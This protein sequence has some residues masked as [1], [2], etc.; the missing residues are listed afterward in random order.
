M[1]GQR[2]RRGSAHAT[3]DSVGPPVRRCGSP[4]RVPPRPVTGFGRPPAPAPRE[5]WPAPTGARVTLPAAA[6]RRPRA[7]ASLTS[8]WRCSSR[9]RACSCCTRASSSARAAFNCD[10]SSVLRANCQRCTPCTGQCRV[11]LLARLFQPLV[12]LLIALELLIALLD[13]LRRRRRDMSTVAPRAAPRHGRGSFSPSNCTENHLS[14]SPAWRGA[15]RSPCPTVGGMRIGAAPNRREPAFAA[16]HLLRG[17]ILEE[18]DAILVDFLKLARFILDQAAQVR[19]V[20]PRCNWAA[21]VQRLPD[22]AP[23]ER[24]RRQG[25]P[26]DGGGHA[27]HRRPGRGGLHCQQI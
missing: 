3:R 27:P 26:M 7:K 16:S 6:H 21:E 18:T 8:F 23:S 24:R 19:V 2:E 11:P 5:V 4:A 12:G 13:Q 9:R 17:R 25:G 14:S 10:V 22:H 20:H 15:R 1:R